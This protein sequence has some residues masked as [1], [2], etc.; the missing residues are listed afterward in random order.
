MSHQTLKRRRVKARQDGVAALELIVF[1]SATMLFWV[2][3]DHFHLLWGNVHH[4][5]MEAGNLVF[6]RSIDKNTPGS[7]RLPTNQSASVSTFGGAGNDGDFSQKLGQ[8]SP[9]PPLAYSQFL[10]D[11]KLANQKS[12]EVGVRVSVRSTGTGGKWAK[13]RT[14]KTSAVVLSTPIEPKGIP[15]T[16]DAY[17]WKH[18]QRV[19]RE[20]S[21]F[22]GF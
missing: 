13:K 4:I 1:F 3:S 14:F 5:K 20:I 8:H 16:R 12:G 19:K 11:P 15:S 9:L 22:Q 6:D 21:P 18:Y 10:N 17:D 2:A 7:V